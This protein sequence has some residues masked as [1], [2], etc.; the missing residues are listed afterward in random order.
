MAQTYKTIKRHNKL[1]YI[2]V[3]NKANSKEGIIQAF[4][5]DSADGTTVATINLRTGKITYHVELPETVREAIEA[6]EGG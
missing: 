4:E 3:I 6:T 5:K 2:L 1:E